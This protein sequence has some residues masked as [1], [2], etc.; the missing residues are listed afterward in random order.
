MCIVIAII[1]ASVVIS[2]A[3]DAKESKLH[4]QTIA[5]SCDHIIVTWLLTTVKVIAIFL[6]ATQAS[7]SANSE[8]D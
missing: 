7:P 1:V 5:L 2:G 6:N 3:L 4:S 8:Q